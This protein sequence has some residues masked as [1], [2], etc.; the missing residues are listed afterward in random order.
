MDN[1]EVCSILKA[2]HERVTRLEA[3][4]GAVGGFAANA[5]SNASGGGSRGGGS[6]SGGSSTGGGTSRPALTARSLTK[7][8]LDGARAALLACKA[9]WEKELNNGLQSLVNAMTL[10]EGLWLSMYNTTKDN[11]RYSSNG[12]RQVSLTGLPLKKVRDKVNEYIDDII[13]Q[14]N[15]LG[16]YLITDGYMFKSIEKFKLTCE[17]VRDHRLL[18]AGGK[19][20]ARWDE[21]ESDW[22]W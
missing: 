8:E 21:P 5:I 6:H 22:N 12:E 7:A 18:Q 13:R 19:V 9:N 16:D 4:F 15:A 11:I 1:Y 2:L 14:G 17:E 10:A 3:G 20:G